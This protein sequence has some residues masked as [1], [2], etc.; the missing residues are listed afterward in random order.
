MSQPPGRVAGVIASL[1]SP[2][3]WNGI[4]LVVNATVASLLG[5]AYWYA[6]AHLATKRTVGEATAFVSAMMALSLIAQLSLPGLLTS[7]LP[8][9]GERARILVV[10]SY[11][12]AGGLSLCLG[13]GFSA[14]ASRASSSFHFLRSFPHALLFT[15]AIV[16]WS[17]FSLQDNALTGLRKAIWVPIENAIFSAVKLIV[18][19]VIGSGVTALGFMVS[20]II[21]AA[22]ALFPISGMLLF[23]LLPSQL[24]LRQE[25]DYAGIRTYFF[26]DSL[27]LM[28][29]QVSTTFLPALVAM[30]LG[31]SPAA[32][33]GMA[34]LLT[35][36]LDLVA[37]NLGMSLTVE[38]AHD[39]LGL[40]KMV[41]E[42]RIRTWS[43]V[44]PAM[45]LGIILA[46]HILAVFGPAYRREGTAVLQ[47][48]LLGSAGRVV[49][50]Q[51]TSAARAARNP[52]FIVQ[53]QVAL[54]LFIPLPVVLFA[55]SLGLKGVA[56]VWA[57]GQTLAA[58]LALSR[59]RRI[60]KLSGPA[61]DGAIG[62][63]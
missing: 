31:S 41:R 50:S 5:Y 55:P 54:L 30:R 36:S 44:L 23:K 51:S 3:Y 1:R 37:I 21:P 45:A 6:A 46:P 12:L 25:R 59:E 35:Q 57:A 7:F 52:A 28:I 29:S 20:W 53:L 16:I 43:V 10:K 63:S 9:A 32:S 60:F 58:L 26:G 19:L 2:L 13:I 24:S 8:R 62:W 22:F 14:A 47:L 27:G 38:G 34:F 48:L 11:L 40:P 61:S 49:V 39:E 4:A 56:A 17:I 18:L 42:L 33:F 15:A